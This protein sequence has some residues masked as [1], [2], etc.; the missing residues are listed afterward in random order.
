MTGPRRVLIVGVNVA[1]L[2]AAERLRALDYDGSLTLLDSDVD[3]P[4]NRPPL[5]KEFLAGEVDE[6]DIKLLSDSELDA[7]DANIWRGVEARGLDLHRQVVDTSNGELPYDALL[8]STGAT[9]FVPDSW[10]AWRGVYGLRTLDDARLIR[11]ELTAGSPRV[12]VIGGGLIGCEVAASA[13]KLGLDVTLVEADSRLFARLLPLAFATAVAR[14]HVDRGVRV[15]LD[16]AVR[17]GAR[18]GR[19]SDRG[20]TRRRT[21]PTGRSRSRRHRRSAKHAMARA[22]RTPTAGR[23]ADRRCVACGSGRVRRR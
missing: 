8:I 19:R 1:G 6:D 5:S 21:R 4:Y 10:S 15:L 20:R 18:Y 12:V 9:A 14:M 7:L 11:G 3:A 16:A 23:G 13:R 17:Q 22:F 2:Q